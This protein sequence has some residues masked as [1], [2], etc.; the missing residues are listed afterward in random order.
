MLESN[1]MESMFFSFY[2]IQGRATLSPARTAAQV[3][4]DINLNGRPQDR[5]DRCGAA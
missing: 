3:A 1:R 5:A 2:T 4:I